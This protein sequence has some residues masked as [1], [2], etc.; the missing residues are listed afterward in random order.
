MSLLAIMASCTDRPEKKYQEPS[1]EN[2]DETSGMQSWFLSTGDWETDPQIYVRE[3]GTGNDTIVLLHGG[4]GAEHSGMIDMVKGLEN[5]CKFFAFEQRGSLR[6]PF[7]DSLITYDNHIKDVERLREETGL[8]KI[9]ILGHSMGSVLASAYANRYPD[10]VEKLILISPA[11]LKNPFPD[12]DMELL[13]NSQ[14]AYE[15]FSSKERL[16]EELKR[17]NLLREQPK[18]SSKEETIK[19]RINFANMML[20]DIGKWNKLNNG[21][22]LYKGNVY[23]LTERTYPE[24]GWDFI[25]DF[26]EQSYDI[27]VIIGDHDRFDMGNHIFRKWTSEVP[28]AK[29]TSIEK[30]GHLLWIDQPEDLTK[31]LEQI[32]ND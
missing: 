28:R 11:F 3:F 24:K 4:W 15:N 32:I 31:T 20:Y 19:N 12:E 13:Q 30:A 7:P 26:K 27:A 9:T 5:Q 16:D 1:S 2:Q 8:E 22:A 17:Q 23:G 29:F 21:K 10:N 14:K 6:S 25:E 18:L